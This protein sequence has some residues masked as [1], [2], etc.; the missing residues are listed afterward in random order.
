MIDRTLALLRQRPDLAELAAFPFDFDIDR[1]YHCEDV[2]LASG[3]SLEPV[4]GDDTG[5]TYFV[6]ADGAVLYASSEGE[7]GLIGESVTDALEIIIGGGGLHRMEIG[8]C[9]DEK[10]LLAEIREEEDE[11]RASYAPDLDAQRAALLDGLGLPRRS[12]VELAFRLDSVARR[13]DPDHVL[14]NSAELMAYQFLDDRVR[15]PL[16]DAALA[17]GRADL[18]RMR[19]GGLA[20]WEDAGSDPARRAGVLRAAQFDR[21]ADDLPLLRYLL[22]REAAERTEHFRERRLAA[23]LVGLHGHAEDLPLVRAAGNHLPPSSA[24][25]L[26]EWARQEDAAEFGQDPAAEDEFTWIALARRQGRTEFVRAA[27]IRM[28]DDT[29]PKAERLAALSRELE[30]IGDHPQ[31]ARAHH[32]FVSLQDTA[33]DRAVACTKL[34]EL[35][36]LAGDLPSAGRA[37]ERVRTAIGLDAPAAQPRDRQ[38]ALDLGSAAE[39]PAPDTSAAEWHRRGLGRRITEQHLELV[40]AAVEAGRPELAEEAMAHGKVLLKTIA[41][42]SRR[43]LSELSSRAK[44]AV[45]ALRTGRSGVDPAQ[46]SK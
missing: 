44:W 20:A 45:A 7:A 13:T 39:G 26:A 10:Q 38:L 41:K 34:A 3:A 27:L 16:P 43:S 29:G 28:L 30:L 42:E 21:R 33:W 4:A 17:P 31:A 46:S 36:R 15:V 35:H 9:L 5:G 37:L 1:A 19:T 18:E 32:N 22:E 2:R 23:V 11:M 8:P 12:P 14:L 6:C 24:S 25:E 40:L